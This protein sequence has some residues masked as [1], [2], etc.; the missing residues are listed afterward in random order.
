MSRIIRYFL[1][2]GDM[3]EVTLVICGLVAFAATLAQ[4]AL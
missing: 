1:E 4:L 2:D 3:G